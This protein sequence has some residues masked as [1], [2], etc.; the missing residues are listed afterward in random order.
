MNWE[1]LLVAVISAMA[2]FAFLQVWVLRRWVRRIDKNTYQVLME[3][4]SR[5]DSLTAGQKAHREDI[6]KLLDAC[7][8]IEKGN[9]VESKMVTPKDL[10]DKMERKR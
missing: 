1:N 8:G 3:H 9:G 2:V 6:E 7:P 4:K 5:M 10:T